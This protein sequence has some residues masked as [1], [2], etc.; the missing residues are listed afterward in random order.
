MIGRWTP[1]GA[2]TEKSRTPVYSEEEDLDNDDPFADI[3]SQHMTISNEN[4]EGTR[5]SGRLEEKFHSKDS[6]KKRRKSKEKRSKKKREG[7]Q[8]RK[9]NHRKKK[10]RKKKV[11]SE[12]EEG[13][14]S[15]E[16]RPGGQQIYGT[17]H[18]GGVSKR[19]LPSMFIGT[20]R[21]AP[22]AQRG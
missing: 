18:P 14:I 11:E 1:R 12:E 5:E 20:D 8:A 13:E 21:P 15:E 3:L 7:K 4:P 16:E 19:E 22:A 6:S 10:H 17:G 9:A 2:G